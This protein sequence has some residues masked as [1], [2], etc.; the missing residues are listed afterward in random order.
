MPKNARLVR[1]IYGIGCG[2]LGYLIPVLFFYRVLAVAENICYCHC[3]T[4][5]FVDDFVMIFKHIT[6]AFSKNPQ[7]F[8]S[9]L[10]CFDVFTLS[11]LISLSDRSDLATISFFVIG[12]PSGLYPTGT[13]F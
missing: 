7:V 10:T 5:N 6:M 8:I 2:G 1:W 12:M 4:F 9:S 13:D 11:S 3:F